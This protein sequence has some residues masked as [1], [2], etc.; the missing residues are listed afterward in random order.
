MAEAAEESILDCF[1]L[2]PRKSPNVSLGGQVKGCNKEFIFIEITEKE[3]SDYLRANLHQFY[4]IIFHVNRVP[5]QLQHYALEWI[6]SH[7]LFN[8]LLNNPKFEI[9][10][11]NLFGTQRSNELIDENYVFR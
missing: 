1:T 4:D 6:E 11:F 10:D 9:V 7:R 8:V 3:H 2:I 5:F